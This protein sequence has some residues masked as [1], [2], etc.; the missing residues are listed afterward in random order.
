[1]SQLQRG[2]SNG[3]KQYFTKT[4]KIGGRN[5]SIGTLEVYDDQ[6]TRKILMDQQGITLE[7]GAKLIGGNGVLSVFQFTSG[8]QTLLQS[9]SKIGFE[10]NMSGDFYR[11]GVEIPVFIPSDFEIVS[12]IITMYHTPMY[13]DTTSIGGSGAEWCYARKVKVY[14]ATNTLNR[15]V[16]GDAFSGGYEEG[17]ATNVE[18]TGVFGTNGFTATAPTTFPPATPP[19]QKI[20]SLDIGSL[21]EEELNII[22]I[23]SDETMPINEL[24]ASQRTGV[25]S[26]TITV[27]GY[28][29]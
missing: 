23:L 19:T 3:G 13:L 9:W 12:A 7:N 5:N 2:T 24:Q 16:Y 27:I 29:K 26:A 22:R 10:K 17:G 6:D 21:L 11:Y 20:V 28:K 14:K 1:M 4:L 15:Y 18:I 25:A 8:G